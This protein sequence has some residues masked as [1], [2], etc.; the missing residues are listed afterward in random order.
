V[1]SRQSFFQARSSAIAP[2]IG[3]AMTTS[4]MLTA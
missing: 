2:A 4:N 1:A 3:D